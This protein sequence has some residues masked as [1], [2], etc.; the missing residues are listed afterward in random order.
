V[1]GLLG[2]V[3]HV[4]ASTADRAEHSSC[5]ITQIVLVYPYATCAVCVLW[6]LCCCAAAVLTSQLM[7]LQLS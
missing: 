6:V 2:P 3:A 4:V 7:R 1:L 5:K